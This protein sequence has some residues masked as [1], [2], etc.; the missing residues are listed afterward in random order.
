M[1]RS[2]D[3]I[4]LHAV[5]STKYRTPFIDLSI[6]EGLHGVIASNF[7]KLGCPVHI[8]NG[9]YDH[10]NV[11]FSLS[12]TIAVADLLGKVKAISSGWANRQGARYEEFEWQEG[13]SVFSADY[14]KLE[15]LINYVRNQKA[16]HGLLPVI[17]NT[18]MGWNFREEMTTLLRAYGFEDFPAKYVFP[19]PPT[20]PGRPGEP[21][22]ANEPP[23]P[24]LA[25]KNFHLPF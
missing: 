7:S 3:R 8:V 18:S 5:W 6:E 12:R 14:R 25:I 1:G 24:Y 21:D 4:V 16:H 20:S 13:Y 2:F 19:D 22:V 15:G 10:V 17:P 11:V 9:T 23:V